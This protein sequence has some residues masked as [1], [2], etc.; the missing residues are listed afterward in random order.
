MLSA[1]GF[2]SRVAQIFVFSSTIILAVIAA[3]LELLGTAALVIG[4]FLYAGYATAF[5]S[6][7]TIYFKLRS[8]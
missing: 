6:F 4:M 3:L 2:F 5:Q 8:L 7:R 1:R